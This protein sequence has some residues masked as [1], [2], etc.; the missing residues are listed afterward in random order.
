MKNAYLKTEMSKHEMILNQMGGDVK[1]IR[2]IMC[3]VKFDIKGTLVEYVYHI[4]NSDN[5]FLQ[6]ISPYPMNMGTYHNKDQIITVIKHD[7]NQFKNASNS[8]V[9]NDFINVNKR[10]NDALRHFEDLYLY[11]NIP[12]EI[13]NQLNDSIDEMEK[14]IKE[15]KNKCKRVYFEKDPD[16]I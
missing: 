6:R 7:I 15:Y 11:Y 1:V 3:Y 16:T 4:N 8:T 12:H 13:F 2:G 10:F 5:Y 9:F 14:L